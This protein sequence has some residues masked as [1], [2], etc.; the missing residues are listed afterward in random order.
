MVQIGEHKS[1]FESIL[2]RKL[3]AALGFK[4]PTEVVDRYR[5]APCGVSPSHKTIQN[6]TEFVEVSSPRHPLKCRR[7]A[8]PCVYSSMSCYRSSLTYF[9]DDR[10]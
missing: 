9:K 3:G 1:H 5:D 2:A 7:H 10:Q 4:A 8:A 6:K